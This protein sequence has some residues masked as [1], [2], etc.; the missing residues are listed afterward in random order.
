MYKRAS[1]GYKNNIDP[2]LETSN[3]F[4][5]VEIPVCPPANDEEKGK[6]EKKRRKV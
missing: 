5:E 3:V 4:C 1:K 6:T 2:T